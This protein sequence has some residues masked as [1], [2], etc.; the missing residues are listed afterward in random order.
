[1]HD[2]FSLRLINSDQQIIGIK[3]NEILDI[4]NFVKACPLFFSALLK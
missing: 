3:I 2:L 4:T 1:M